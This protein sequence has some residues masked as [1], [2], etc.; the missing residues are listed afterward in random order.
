MT[1]CW[2]KRL[3]KFCNIGFDAVTVRLHNLFHRAVY[4]NDFII[5]LIQVVENP[6]SG[7]HNSGYDDE[8]HDYIIHPGELFN[9]RLVVIFL[10]VVNSP[11][12]LHVVNR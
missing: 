12:D 3:L 5:K 1:R 10:H 6:R 9:N 2:I 7:S 8:N 4:I 11:C